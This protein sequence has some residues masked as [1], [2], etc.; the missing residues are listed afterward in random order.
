MA[1]SENVPVVAASGRGQSKRAAGAAAGGRPKKSTTNASAGNQNARDEIA[2]LK[3]M[4]TP[5]ARMLADSL[6]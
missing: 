5:L 3:G 1:N 2:R 4:A 6:G